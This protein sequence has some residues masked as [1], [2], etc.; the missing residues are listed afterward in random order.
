LATRIQ[1]QRIKGTGARK[2]AVP[3]QEPDFYSMLSLPTSEMANHKAAHL[4]TSGTEM[5]NESLRPQRSVPGLPSPRLA[6]QVMGIAS[7]GDLM[8][9]LGTTRLSALSSNAVLVSASSTSI[10]TKISAAKLAALIGATMPGASYSDFASSLILNS[11]IG[12]CSS[13]LAAS[14]GVLNAYDTHATGARVRQLV[15]SNLQLIRPSCLFT[16][17]TSFFNPC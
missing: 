10:A 14:A 12:S 2:A 5:L 1:R 15:Q 8:S 17:P 7:G 16:E 9:L 6:G 13:P 11:L 3:E 4:A